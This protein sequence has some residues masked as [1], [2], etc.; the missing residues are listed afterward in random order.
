MDDYLAACLSVCTWSLA[1]SFL[2]LSELRPYSWKSSRASLSS[3]IIIDA[4]VIT[5][6]P[7]MSHLNHD[8]CVPGKQVYKRIVKKFGILLGAVLHRIV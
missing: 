7:L 6:L 8:D 2:T 1:T 3:K 5:F 4:S